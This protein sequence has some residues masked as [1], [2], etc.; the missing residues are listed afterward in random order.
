MEGGRAV[1][2][3]LVPGLGARARSPGLRL[4]VYRFFGIPLHC[5]SPSFLLLTQKVVC[6]AS[7]NH[8]ASL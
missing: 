7:R 5:F 8:G 2:L 1:N 3:F 6:F 4:L